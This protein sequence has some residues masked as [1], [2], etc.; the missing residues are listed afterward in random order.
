MSESRILHRTVTDITIRGNMIDIF[1]YYVDRLKDIIAFIND[2]PKS[3]DYVQ[4]KENELGIINDGYDNT[5][6]YLNTKG[7]LI[8]FS[9]ISEDF[10]IN[11]EGQLTLAE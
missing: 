3:I 10:D 4:F 7:E 9:D 1:T 11:E 2:S 5:S 6:F 8:V